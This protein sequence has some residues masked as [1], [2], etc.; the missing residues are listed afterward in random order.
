M[1]TQN[2]FLDPRRAESEEHAF[3]AERAW[4][5]GRRDEA[6][7]G[8][9]LAAQLEEAVARTVPPTSTRVRSLLAIS[10][11]SLW[12]KAN[13]LDRAKRL[14]H[15]FLADGGLTEQGQRDLER[16]VDACCREMELAGLALDPGII[17][18]EVK[19]SK[20]SK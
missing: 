19:P 5:D 2:P 7:Q 14:A 3:R 11:V 18:V 17:P 4:A 12:Y 6:L 9:E 16:L 20:R 10:A 1:T 13:Q 8:F 15:V